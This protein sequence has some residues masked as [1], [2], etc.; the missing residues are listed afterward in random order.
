MITERELLQSIAKCYSEDN[1]DAR[2]CR[3]LASYYT[4]L[5]HIEPVT[6]DVRY[7]DSEL[8]AVIQQKGLSE[9]LPV[10]DELLDAVQTTNPRLY[11]SFIRKLND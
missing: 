10:L 5:D 3:N 11:A 1:P 4:I 7:T 6:Y 8:S 2:T 9:V